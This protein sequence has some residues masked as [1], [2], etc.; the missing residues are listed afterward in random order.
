MMDTPPVM[1]RALDPR[2]Y[3][4][5]AVFAREAEKIFFRNWIY[6]GHSSQ[7]AQAGDFFYPDPH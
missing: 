3:T 2:Y 7:V 4:D 5:A 6:A 1:E